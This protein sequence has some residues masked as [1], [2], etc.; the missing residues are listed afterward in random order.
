MEAAINGALGGRAVSARHDAAIEDWLDSTCS[1]LSA[2]CTQPRASGT[3][4]VNLTDCAA[5]QQAVDNDCSFDVGSVMEFTKA[6]RET[7]GS[8][9]I[10]FWV[11]PVGA[12]SLLASGPDERFFP[13]IAFLSSLSPPQPQLTLG[14]WANA[15]GEFRV[16]S[17][18]NPPEF[19][20]AKPQA[21]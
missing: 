2:S 6:V 20:F 8:W 13:H 4:W 7:G 14:Y 17:R 15:N 10:G 18:C 19:R 5:T 21:W 12:A 1:E 16:N 9:S 11:R 3:R